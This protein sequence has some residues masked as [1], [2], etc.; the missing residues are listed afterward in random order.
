MS[1]PRVFF[2]LGLHKT[3][4]TWFQRALFP[5]LPQV[6][7]KRARNFSAIDGI[8][9]QDRS[10]ILII[11]HEGLS[12]SISMQKCSGDRSKRLRESIARISEISS[13]T[14]II[15]GFREQASWINSAYAEKTK[16]RPMGSADY[17]GSY[18]P[19][20]LS[21]CKILATADQAPV[22][23]FAFL[24]EELNSDPSALVADLCRFLG[25]TEPSNLSEILAKRE[26]LS[27]RGDLGQRASRVFFT[28]SRILKPIPYLS[29]AKRPLRGLGSKLGARLDRHSAPAPTIAF[30]DELARLLH[31]DW[32]RLVQT[33][34]ERRGR[35][36][37]ALA[38]DTA[39][40]PM[41]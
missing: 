10:G 19:D 34:G 20:D 8:L 1:S 31:A 4:T 17:I 25:T 30:N 2:H 7:T 39:S 35:D 12:G 29:N 9:A 38:K 16:K 41:A 5:K 37:S 21:W 24:Y 23:V 13:C 26:N 36:F 18:S 27:P 6:S 32:N 33:V 22:P 15:I 28:I 40:L 14:G 3:G 11:S